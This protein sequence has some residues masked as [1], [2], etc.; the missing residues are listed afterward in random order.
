MSLTT[1]ICQ[2]SQ[3]FFHELPFDR[4][5]NAFCIRFIFRSILFITWWKN[6]SLLYQPAIF[7]PEVAIF[8][9]T[10]NSLLECWVPKKKSAKHTT[11][12]RIEEYRFDVAVSQG[13]S[14][15][16]EAASGELFHAAAAGFRYALARASITQTLSYIP[17]QAGYIGTPLR[18]SH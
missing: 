7:T 13:Q 18:F 16:F 8:I 1:L 17:A 3:A 6:L 15:S 4:Y 11:W 10:K 5:K 2:V 12:R 9:G 14:A